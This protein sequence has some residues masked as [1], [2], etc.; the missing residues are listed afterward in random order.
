M[1]LQPEQKVQRKQSDEYI[2]CHETK[3]VI[4]MNRLK[5]LA[6]RYSLKSRAKIESLGN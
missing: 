1:S 3:S 4:L 6:Y 5:S 2:V